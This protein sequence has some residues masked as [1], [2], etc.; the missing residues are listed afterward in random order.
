[1]TD[2]RASA[3]D[4]GFIPAA[5][6]RAE[7]EQLVRL[8]RAHDHATWASLF[9]RYYPVLCRYAYARLGSSTEAEDVASHTFL[10]AYEAIGR[11]EYRERP[12]LAWLH[13]I[14]R[15][16]ANKRRGSSWAR[17]VAL[18]EADEAAAQTPEA[19]FAN[20]L[21]LMEAVARLKDQQRDVVI[22][23]FS[24]GMSLRETAAVL[25]TTEAAVH[26]LQ[27]RALANLRLRL[28]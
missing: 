15:N 24:L 25:N 16:L 7:D 10:K 28:K 11:Y 4:L 27:T 14:C 17:S 9:D 18:V 5:E 1:V 26:S 12:M 13:T 8:A 6:A 23:R 21:D 3:A 20:R 19:D 22:L 2:T